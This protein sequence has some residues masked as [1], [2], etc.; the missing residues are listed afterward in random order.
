MLSKWYFDYDDYKNDPENVAP[1]ER[2][3]VQRLVAT[4]PIDRT[5]SSRMEMLKALSRLSFPGY[6]SS[7]FGEK[8]QADG[9]V[10]SGFSVE[11]PMANK[12]RVLVFRALDGAYT[13]VDDFVAPGDPIIA[14]VRQ[15]GEEF[16]YC[17]RQGQVV[18]RRSGGKREAAQQ[19][20]EADER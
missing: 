13:V 20:D 18:L 4:A 7:Q 1:F 3:R 15:E 11:I 2:A 17:T 8:P 16:V 12:E 9:T 19:G 6:G 14:S 5:F 10:L